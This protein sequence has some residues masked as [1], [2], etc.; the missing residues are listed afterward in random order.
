MRDQ[1]LKHLKAFKANR[2]LH[3]QIKD[4]SLFVLCIGVFG[5]L[6]IPDY[7]YIWFSAI[8]S[9]LAV[10]LLKVLLQ[11]RCVWNIAAVRNQGPY[12]GH[13]GNRY[14]Y[15]PSVYI[16]ETGYT[17]NDGRPILGLYAGEFIR[18]NR[19]ARTKQVLQYKYIYIGKMLSGIQ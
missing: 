1:V 5:L 3:E 7:V 19:Y 14:L 15:L 18:K 10:L 16:A 8:W 17:G 6:A 11:P 2:W 13:K 4:F 12:Q 9:S